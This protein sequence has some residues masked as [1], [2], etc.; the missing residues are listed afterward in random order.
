MF[1][2]NT[3]WLVRFHEHLDWALP[4]YAFGAFALAII[5]LMAL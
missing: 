2:Q 4:M 1:D 5:S 3:G